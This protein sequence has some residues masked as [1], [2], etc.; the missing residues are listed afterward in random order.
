MP[1]NVL[2]FKPAANGEPTFAR[3]APTY[4][5]AR[6]L[7]AGVGQTHTIPAGARFALFSGSGNFY[8][9]PNAAATIPGTS[10]TD[11]TS[12]ELNPVI[13]DLN[14]VSTIGL[15]A[16]DDTIVTLSFYL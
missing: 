2:T 15:V 12:G 5:D 6:V 3:S 14:G 1:L 8:A 13:W 7:A 4:I 16:P 11:G 10:V 9:R